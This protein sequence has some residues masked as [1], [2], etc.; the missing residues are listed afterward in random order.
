[1]SDHRQQQELQEELE[2]RIALIESEALRRPLTI[3][4]VTLLQWATGVQHME[5]QHAA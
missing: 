1:M 5:I 2:Q 4:E 3:D